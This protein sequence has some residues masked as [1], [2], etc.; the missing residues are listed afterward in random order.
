MEEEQG[1]QSGTATDIGGTQ[2]QEGQAQQPSASGAESQAKTYT[3]E[4]LNAM[5][6]D[7]VNRAKKSTEAEILKAYGVGSREELD[8]LVSEG[9]KSPEYKKALEAQ[10][11]GKEQLAFALNGIDPEMEDDIRFFFKGKGLE[12]NDANLKAELENGKHRHWKKEGNVA[13]P[14]P[15]QD[16]AQAQT[17][18]KSG[19]TLSPVGAVPQSQDPAYNE[20]RNKFLTAAGVKIKK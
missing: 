14:S 10:A 7:R 17:A 8:S 15:K 20:R 16:T 1:K 11:Q 4:Q 5:F 6:Q 18:T 12:L 3:E 2:P 13:Q 9:K 19:V